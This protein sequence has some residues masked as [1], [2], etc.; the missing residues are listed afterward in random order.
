MNK[1]LLSCMNSFLKEYSIS[2]KDES[3]KFEHFVNYCIFSKY[4]P[5]AYIEE[6]LFYEYVHTGSGG[7][8]AIDG[9]LVLVNDIPVHDIEQFYSVTGTKK[10]FSSK[11]IFVQTKTS[12][13]F[14]AGEILK[15]GNGVVD[16]INDNLGNTNE[17]IKNKKELIKEIYNNSANFEENPECYLYY[18][19]TGKWVGDSVLVNIQ[20]NVENN[21]R[22][23]NMTSDIAFIPI[24]AEKLQQIYR[25]VT[26]SIKKEIQLERVVP[27]PSIPGIDQA[28]LGLVK[29]KDLLHLICDEDGILQ[30]ALFYENVRGFLGDNSVNNE[31]KQTLKTQNNAVCFPVLNN[32]I[33]IVA[34]T[35]NRVGDKF[36]LSDFQ[37]VNGC[38]TC[39]VIYNCKNDFQTD[40]VFCT[41][42]I[43]STEKSDVIVSIT[44]S[45]NRQTNVTDEAFESLRQFH[46]NLQQYYESVSEGEHRLY[47][48]RRS[49]EFANQEKIDRNKIV[50]LTTQI[51][52][53][54]SMFLLEPHSTHR[55]YG[56]LL[57]SY[58]KKIFNDGDILDLYYVA[59][60]CLYNVD[61]IIY[62]DKQFTQL[63]KYR[64]HFVMII[65]LIASDN[66]ILKLRFNSN[67]AQ[68]VAETICKKIN[69][70]NIFLS[71]MKQSCNILAQAIKVL[72]ENENTP[73]IRKRDFTN[74]IIDLITKL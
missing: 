64:Y 48:E 15:M 26:H 11:F 66:H 12:S 17:K 72:P 41:L 30:N 6:P 60:W 5:E 50:S 19:T 23:L 49:R 59:T 39:N 9:L 32:G 42:K 18:A 31:I 65:G 14:D 8:C 34:K 2:E 35:L 55:Y 16:I 21:I 52:S 56:E 46:K 3:T 29:I 54:I 74:V 28:F 53:F 73:N 63:R 1:I 37:V 67:E 68:R 70:K 69:D 36:T 47:Y 51:K 13:S 7:D 27:F 10:Q 20:N 61:Q 22:N 33:T 38:Q 58:K 40:Q 25:N 4:T 71:L 24:D 44:K 57:K 45:T 43:I 62:R